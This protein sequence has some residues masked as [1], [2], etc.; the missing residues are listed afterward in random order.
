MKSAEYTTNLQDVPGI[1]ASELTKLQTIAKRFHF[2]APRKYLRLI[3]S[4]D[5][6]IRRI[7]VPHRDELDMQGSMDP[8]GEHTYTVIP[9]LEHKY[10]ETVLL[11]VSD[12]CEGICRYCFRK[13][14]FIKPD[15]Y[16]T[17]KDFPRA[18]EYIRNYNNH[19]EQKISNVILS[20]GDPFALPL[21]NLEQMVATLSE[22]EGVQAIRIGSKALAYN[23]WKFMGRGT[24]AK[25]AKRLAQYIGPVRLYLINHFDVAKELKYAEEPLLEFEKHRFKLKNQT[26]L[27]KGVNDKPE[28]LG[29]LFLELSRLGVD[30][31]YV[32][33]CRP[34]IGNY[35]YTVPVEEAW[36][37][38]TDA[39]SLCSGLDKKAK[40]VMSHFKGKI[41]VVGPLDLIIDGEL[42]KFFVMKYHRAAEEQN[43]GK[44]FLVESN[45]SARW[46]DDY[47]KPVEEIQ[48]NTLTE[49]VKIR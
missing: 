2:K 48:T 5:S 20:G 29:E 40:L 16:S 13:R 32:F 38:F 35:K 33:I 37:I 39:Q 27:I 14:L 7:V 43:E 22:I 21:D 28:V 3:D 47:E 4:P 23:P 36:Q 15:Q 17:I 9:G 31:Y 1:Q 46:L 10:K 8:S 44:I 12:I 19:Y 49:L 6:P 41:E 26:P 24:H 18:V 30:P 11:L 42:Q 45:P 25:A 34:A